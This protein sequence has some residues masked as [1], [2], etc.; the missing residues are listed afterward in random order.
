MIQDLKDK[1]PICMK[2]IQHFLA[3]LLVSTSL[4]VNAASTV[5]ADCAD[6]SGMTADLSNISGAFNLI[7]E[8]K[9]GDELDQALGELVDAMVL[10]AEAEDS[11][12]LNSAVDSLSQAYNNLDSDKF[13]S[14]LNRVI[15]YMDRMYKRE[16]S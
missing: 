10:V 3:A 8:I 12:R 4:N 15:S 16:C 14:A 13:E 6:L 11:P 9:E 1:G 5:E 7:D 2:R